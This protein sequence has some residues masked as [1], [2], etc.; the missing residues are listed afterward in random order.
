MTEKDFAVSSVGIPSVGTVS[1]KPCYLIT[2]VDPAGKGTVVSRFITLDMPDLLNGFL[3]VK[4]VFV[5]VGEDVI[6]KT[7]TE[8]LAATPKESIMDVMFP[9]HRIH[10]IR[11]L[12]FNANKPATV[13]R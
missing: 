8:L 11:S 3:Q 10:C 9:W 4:G 12:V 7:F 13:I 6:V 1:K 2:L 5:D